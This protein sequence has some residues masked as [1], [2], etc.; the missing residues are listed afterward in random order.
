MNPRIWITGLLLTAF[1]HAPA[2]AASGEDKLPAAWVAGAGILNV[3]HD[4]EGGQW[5]GVL[6][7]RFREVVRGLRPWLGTAHA[8]L[9]TSFES[10]GLLYTVKAGEGWRLSAGWAP[11]Y[12][13]QRRGKDLG[14][15]LVFYSF[16][17]AGYAFRSQQAVSVRFGHLSNGG[18]GDHNPG[19]ETL[20]VSY[21]LPFGTGH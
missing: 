1:F 19:I 2:R 10:A 12:Y 17:E 14:S 7:Y 18:L 5:M 3:L 6:E 8:E 4:E 20:Q 11:T 21:S 16:A 13:D 9:G 15:D